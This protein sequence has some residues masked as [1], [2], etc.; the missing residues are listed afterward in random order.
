MIYSVTSFQI[1][2]ESPTRA[3]LATPGGPAAVGS[4]AGW[5]SCIAAEVKTSHLPTSSKTILSFEP[6][7]KRCMALHR[8]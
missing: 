8:S 7:E 5:L 6:Q 1:T 2:R 3:T 4:V